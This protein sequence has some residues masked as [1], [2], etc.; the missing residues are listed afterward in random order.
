M[1]NGKRAFEELC[2]RREATPID[3]LLSHKQPCDPLLFKVACDVAVRPSDA[4]EALG[5][6]YHKTPM[7]LASVS[8]PSGGLKEGVSLFPHQKEAV[9]KVLAK[10]GNLLLSHPVGSGKCVRGDTLVLT[11]RGMVPIA[12]LFPPEAPDT[13]APEQFLPGDGLCVP[14]YSESGT[15]W[16]PVLVR[17]RQRIVEQT[18]KIVVR[19]DTLDVTSAHP[20]LVASNGTVRWVPAGD[21]REGDLVSTVAMLNVP[22][23]LERSMDEDLAILMAWQVAEGYESPGKNACSITQDNVPLLQELCARMARLVPSYKAQLVTPGARSPYM[24]FCSEAYKNMLLAQ[25]YA[26]GYKSKDKRLPAW[27]PL[28]EKELLGRSWLPCS[29]RRVA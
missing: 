8:A 4:Y 19:G 14:G 13:D 3:A 5:G 21:V 7:K 28:L 24:R 10:D 6:T 12:S 1:S 18:R 29:Q 16:R 15:C 2:G 11:Q 27:I 17:Y 22:P 20:L 23:E 9:A 26:W 25:G